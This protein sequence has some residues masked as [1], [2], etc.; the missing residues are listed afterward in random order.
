MIIYKSFKIFLKIIIFPFIFLERMRW[1]SEWYF[2]RRC[3]PPPPHFIKQALLSRHG[4]SNSIWVETGT[5]LGQTTKF[6]C[7]NFAFVHS[8]EPSKKCLKIAKRNLK[9]YKNVSLYEGTSE[10]CLDSICSSL[11][12]DICFWLDGHY[13]EGI[14]YKGEKDTPILFELETIKNYLGNFSNTVIVIDDIRTSHI[15]KKN[16][17]PLNFYVNWAESLGLDWIIELDSFI[18]KSKGLPFYK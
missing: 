11:K 13:S 14:T 18:I 15:D 10:S 9:F 3:S 1:L 4:I 12:G 17:P 16:Y 8:I 6:L 2:S 7:S 5:Y